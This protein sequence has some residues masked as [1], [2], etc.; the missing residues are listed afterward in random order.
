MISQIYQPAFL[1]KKNYYI[2]FDGA[3]DSA[4]GQFSVVQNYSRY[5]IWSTSCF[6]CVVTIALIVLAT[7]SPNVFARQS[8]MEQNT[9]SYQYRKIMHTYLFWNNW[10]LLACM[11][12]L[13]CG[14]FTFIQQLKFVMIIKYPDDTIAH[15][16][17]M[18]GLFN[19]T[20]N[21]L[22]WVGPNV[23]PAYTYKFI[24]K[25]LVYGWWAPLFV[26]VAFV[27]KG[28]HAA[29]KY[30]IK[31]PRQIEY[32]TRETYANTCM[33]CCYSKSKE[34]QYRTY[35]RETFAIAL[36]QA[37]LLEAFDG[38]GIPYKGPYL[39]V[40]G[41]VPTS[42][43]WAVID[44]LMDQGIDDQ[45]KL[46]DLIEMDK[47][48][49]LAIQGIQ[50]GAIVKI[51]NAF[52]IGQC[53]YKQIS[54][55]FRLR[56][57]CGP[58]CQAPPPS[59]LRRDGTTSIYDFRMLTRPLDIDDAVLLPSGPEVDKETGQKRRW[60]Q[61]FDMAKWDRKEREVANSIS[62]NLHPANL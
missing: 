42:E 48:S 61:P 35:R 49:L 40:A 37:G 53:L 23:T 46:F 17:D 50:L 44:A 18:I 16:Q 47:A 57:V 30:P 10:A 5:S 60:I 8:D 51:C 6:C 13:M 4:G 39:S 1:T 54:N 56:M 21:G 29:Y 25:G 43:L 45:A 59:T 3:S 14:F 7:G 26:V 28:Q 9:I 24:E 11:I 55:F 62:L 19:V 31:P 15:V 34:E 2:T 33:P 41:G 36:K 12:L 32:G 27:S 38:D 58:R 20:R 22:D 52:R